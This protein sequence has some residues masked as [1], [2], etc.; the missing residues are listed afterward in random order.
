MRRVLLAYFSR[1]GENYYYGGR[2]DLRAGNTEV[3]A[4]KI[5]DRIAATPTA[6]RPP[7]PTRTTTTPP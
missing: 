3:L 6:S 5:A 4:D 1:T 2:T 7:T